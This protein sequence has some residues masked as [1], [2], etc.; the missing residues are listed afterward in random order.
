LSDHH[1]EQ[2]LPPD[3]EQPSSPACRICGASTT[4]VAVVYGSFSKRDYHLARCSECG[5]AFIVDPWLDFAQIYDESYYSGRGADPLADYRYEL[6]HPERTIRRYEWDGIATV[7]ADLLATRERATQA[8]S[9]GDLRWLDYGCGNGGL[10]RHLRARQGVDA[11]GFDEGAITAEASL[12]GTP[13]LSADD[14]VA[15]AGSFDV[16]T[17]IEVLEHTL[18]PV[19][20]LRRIRRLLRPGGLFFL[21]TG[22]AEPY[23]RRLDRWRYV[24]PELHISYFEP[25]TLDR[26]LTLA[27]FRPE[28]RQLGPGFDLILKFKVLKNLRFRRRSVFTDAFPASVA[29]LADRRTR[30][31]E[32]PVGWAS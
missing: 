4:P 10:V 11:F 3:S 14:L 28:H 21:T 5:F 7:V 25:R 24:L 26:A 8:P 6:E 23:A 29:A 17:A 32:H 31:S 2:A 16:V 18:D 20:E 22:N 19:T 1:L 12:R 9:G 30:L 15:S 13:T 27:G